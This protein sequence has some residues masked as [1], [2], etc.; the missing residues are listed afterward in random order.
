MQSLE[1]A[2]GCKRSFAGYG[3]ALEG[4]RIA[5]GK[6]QFFGAGPSFDLCLALAGQGKSRLRFSVNER[7]RFVIAVV[8]HAIPSKWS[9]IRWRRSFVDPT[10]NMPDGRRRM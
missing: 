3:K 4:F 9:A 2:A 6:G 1:A 8:L 10:Y 7:Q 5:A